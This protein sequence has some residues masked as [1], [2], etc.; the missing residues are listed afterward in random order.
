MLC[1]AFFASDPSALKQEISM[2]EIKE[3]FLKE[4]TDGVLVRENCRPHTVFMYQV[5]FLQVLQERK[6]LY[7]ERIDYANV[8]T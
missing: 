4:H 3:H 7:L 2:D 6:V 1:F 8:Y 5:K